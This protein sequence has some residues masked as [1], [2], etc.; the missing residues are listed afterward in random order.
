MQR[1]E[2]HIVRRTIHL[3]TEHN[4]HTNIISHISCRKSSL[5]FPFHFLSHSPP[6][7]H[8]RSR[9]LPLFLVRSVW[10]LFSMS[11]TIDSRLYRLR[12]RCFGFFEFFANK[13][14]ITFLW[15]RLF[16]HLPCISLFWFHRSTISLRRSVRYSI[17]KMIYNGSIRRFSFLFFFF[18]LLNGV[19]VAIA[20][21]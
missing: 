17:C 3:F 15:F 12:C 4:T 8:Y 14:I 2:R 20:K 21:A 19:V 5:I 9:S 1:I 13:K 10:Q 11:P 7:L 16:V 18:F 6:L